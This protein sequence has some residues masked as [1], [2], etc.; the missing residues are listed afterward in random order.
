MLAND[1]IINTG[2]SV[3]TGD[4]GTILKEVTGFPPG[5]LIGSL[6]PEDTVQLAHA[7]TVE[8]NG[9]VFEFENFINIENTIGDETLTA[10]VYHLEKDLN[11]Q[12]TLVLDGPGE[13]IFQI[14]SELAT[15]NNTQLVLTGG[16][17]AANISWATGG[18]ST[19]GSNTTFFGNLF[20]TDMI[21]VGTGTSVLGL[22]STGASI[23]MDSSIISV[24][25]TDS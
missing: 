23:V 15:A 4:I 5:T 17:V 14:S 6:Q 19:F 16:A 11:I 12:G 2:P 18:T 9:V 21:T 25:P 20:S 24:A 3:I 1:G 10:G 22:I 13:F 8:A 7:D